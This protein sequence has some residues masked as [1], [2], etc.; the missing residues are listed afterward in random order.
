VKVKEEEAHC[1]EN[2]NQ[3]IVP[4]LRIV[5]NHTGRKIRGGQEIDPNSKTCKEIRGMEIS[6]VQTMASKRPH[7]E[8]EGKEGGQT[9]AR[10]ARH[11]R[12]VREIVFSSV[13]N[14]ERRLAPGRNLREKKAAKH[15]EASIKAAKHHE[16]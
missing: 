6:S 2:I 12:R 4:V 9:I 3:I 15:Y 13:V 1:V 14:S 10:T 16:A 5:N 11:Q 7:N 8:T